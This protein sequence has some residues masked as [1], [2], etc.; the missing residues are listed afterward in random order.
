MS[1]ASKYCTLN[2][3]AVVKCYVSNHQELA[4]RTRTCV[5]EI[6]YETF[7]FCFGATALRCYNGDNY[8]ALIFTM[9][10]HEQQNKE[11]TFICCP[12]R[13][14]E[15][16]QSLMFLISSINFSPAHSNLL[17]SIISWSFLS[18]SISISW[19]PAAR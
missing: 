14:S 19:S 7:A 1:S 13:W 4:P 16:H 3:S 17:I 18:S 15:H 8:K 5:I 11:S 6:T 2:S 10:S 9:M 12:T